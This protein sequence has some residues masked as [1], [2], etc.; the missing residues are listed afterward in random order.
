LTYSEYLS[1]SGP[2]FGN[3][4]KLFEQRFNF[5]RTL[6]IVIIAVLVPI[7]SLN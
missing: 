4:P 7:P 6:S 2:I 5:A 1:L 3:E